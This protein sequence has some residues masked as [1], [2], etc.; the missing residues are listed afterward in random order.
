MWASKQA[1]YVLCTACGDGKLEGDQAL[2]ESPKWASS[3][4]GPMLRRLPASGIEKREQGESAR[5]R[6]AMEFR[7]WERKLSAMVCVGRL[8]SRGRGTQCLIPTALNDMQYH[9]LRS[10]YEIAARNTKGDTNCR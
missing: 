9:I 4:N 3:C 8:S 10:H 6:P 2:G 1:S 7:V 5:S